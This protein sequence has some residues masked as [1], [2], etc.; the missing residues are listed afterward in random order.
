MTVTQNP[1]GT[2]SHYFRVEKFTENKEVSHSS[3]IFT[4][5]VSVATVD[6]KNS[7]RDLVVNGW[8]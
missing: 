7:S 2:K 8:P 6:K 5:R 4:C 1:A 3:T